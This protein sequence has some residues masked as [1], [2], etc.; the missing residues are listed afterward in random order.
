MKCEFEEKSYEQF[1]NIELLNRSRIFFPPGQIQEHH[2]GIDC[3]LLTKNK[4]F[5]RLWGYYKWWLYPFPPPGVFLNDVFWQELKNTIDAKDFPRFKFNVFIQY[6]RPEYIISVRGKEYRFWKCPYFRYDILQHQQDI[7]IKLEQK[8][9]D[10]AIVVYAAPA[11]HKKKD[12][13]EYFAK[14]KLIE[15]SNYVKPSSLIGHSR[16]TYVNGGIVGL[17]FSEP[18][19]VESISFLKEIE[20]IKEVRYENNSEFI[21]ETSRILIET[22]GEVE[23]YRKAFLR[24]LESFYIPEH[25]LGKALTNIY[26][27]LFLTKIRWGICYM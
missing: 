23:Y 17:A 7:L 10:R 18:K 20:R 8:V 14:R 27:I 19:E 9:R 22:V 11:F 4:K 12:L 13:F 16:W 26:V 6:K 25:P 2:L 21:I 24:F 15:N 1:H 3:M 5:W